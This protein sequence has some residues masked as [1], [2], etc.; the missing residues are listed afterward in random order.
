MR[1]G[2]R[3]GRDA[4][5]IIVGSA[6]DQ[7]GTQ[8]CA[9]RV[10]R[11]RRS[12]GGAVECAVM[13]RSL[14]GTTPLTS[15][16]SVMSPTPLKPCATTYHSLE[17]L[18]LAGGLACFTVAKWRFSSATSSASVAAR[19][20]LGD[21]G[22]ARA[23]DLDRELQSRLDQRHRAQ[24]IG[25]LVADGVRR[26]VRQ[27]EVGR[28]A[29]R[30]ASARPGAA[31]SMKSICRMVTPS[32][33]SVGSRSMPTTAACGTR[34]RTT[35]LQPPGAMPRSTTRLDALQ[36]PEALVELEQFVGGAAA[37]ILRLG[38]LD[39]GIVELPLEPARR[40]DFAALRG[41]RSRFTRCQPSR[42][43]SERR[44]PS[45][46][47]RS[48]MPRFSAGQISM[49]ASR[50]AQPAT[51]RSARS[52]PM[53]GRPE[54]SSESMLGD[55]RADLLHRFDRHVEPVDRAPVVG[56]QREMDAGER[57]HRAA[58]A[59]QADALRGSREASSAKRAKAWR[60]RSR[61]RS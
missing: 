1:T 13:A 25:L 16:S 59:E 61:M 50:I 36:Q 43:I 8:M 60:A 57:R 5:G 12:L 39:V 49:I 14:A 7:A 56:R 2:L 31:S 28:A 55:H 24:M 54:R 47:P 34:R 20:H 40:R 26:H 45:R 4:A 35:W 10:I 9:A 41:L 53:Q 3:V 18:R 48:A 44:M 6:G 27:D 37:V 22:A 21:K 52:L 11:V 51:T 23:Q 33:G 30:L 58:G 29:E 17:P 42:A 19:Q 38:A 32:I 46:M 15:Y